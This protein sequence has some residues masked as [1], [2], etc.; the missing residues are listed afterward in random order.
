MRI[1]RPSESSSSPITEQPIRFSWPRMRDSYCV[2]QSQILAT[3]FFASQVMRVLFSSSFQA[4]AP[5]RPGSQFP[6]D[7]S[8]GIQ[9][10]AKPC[11]RCIRIWMSC[12]VLFNACPRCSA[13][14]T[15]R[16]NNNG[17]RACE[18]DRLP[19]GSN[20]GLPI[21]RRSSQIVLGNRIGSGFRPSSHSSQLLMK[22]VFDRIAQGLP[23]ASIMFSLTPMFSQESDS[24]VLSMFHPEC[25]GRPFPDR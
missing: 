16:W 23:T 2:F 24:S 21:G 9:S 5:L 3:S 8:P 15:S 10:V 4:G 19:R 17:I 14:V 6:R 18:R 12:K 11:M 20:R 7:R 25:G 22:F 1:G 13:P